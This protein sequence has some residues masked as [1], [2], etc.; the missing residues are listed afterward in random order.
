MR[1]SILLVLLAIIVFS[2]GQIL[3]Q[4]IN[5]LNVEEIKQDTFI[6]CGNCYTC[7]MRIEGELTGILGI[8]DVNYQAT[9]E[10]LIL[11]YGRGSIEP[12]EILQL[13]ADVGH[14]NE[15]IRA[16]DEAYNTLVGTCCE[17][18]RWLTYE[19]INE[20]W[21][22]KGT[23]ECQDTIV[24]VL[25][26]QHGVL[27]GSWA[28]SVLSS[29]HYKQITDASRVL[30][31]IAMAGFDNEMY[32]APDDIYESLAEACK[33]ERA[34]QIDTT[35]VTDTTDTTDTTSV[36]SA[37]QIRDLNVF[38]NPTNGKIYVENNISDIITVRVINTAGVEVYINENNN[39]ILEEGVNV[40]S[41][42][43]GIYF[44]VIESDSKLYSTKFIKN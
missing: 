6:V 4:E 3:G 25:L 12:V 37:I 34:A 35:D 13:V 41:F 10:L 32:K 40:E 20:N 38:P 24:N 14:D 15:M 5:I 28:D 21:E 1:Q 29:N 23:V 44:L 8:F 17:Y 9:N 27:S 31:E 26:D 11:S 30:F 22:V 16:T 33:Y 7:K 2:P 18:D 43:N 39:I 36:F 19:T 42:P